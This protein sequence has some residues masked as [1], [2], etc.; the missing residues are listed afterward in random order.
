MQHYML[1]TKHFYTF[2]HS[3]VRFCRFF[4]GFHRVKNHDFLLP[5]MERKAVLSR[6]S[7]IPITVF[8]VKHQTSYFS[9]R[10][11]ASFF[12][13][14]PPP[15]W[16]SETAIG[17]AIRRSMNDDRSFI[18][19]KKKKISRRENFWYRKSTADFPFSF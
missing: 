4:H 19:C 13:P 5:P 14:P 9:L 12:P 17:V 18:H 15:H 8:F 3:F 6:S 1:C 10:R 11:V 16:K 2:F 7:K